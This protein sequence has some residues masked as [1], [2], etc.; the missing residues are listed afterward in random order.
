MEVT[1]GGCEGREV[2]ELIFDSVIIFLLL[3]NHF[4][5]MIY[6][7]D[8]GSKKT[9]EVHGEYKDEWVGERKVFL[10]ISFRFINPNL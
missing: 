10:C 6:E 9:N 7:C 3:M 5:A 2:V 1:Y 4:F 8:I